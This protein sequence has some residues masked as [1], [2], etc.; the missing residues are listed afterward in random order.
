M[1]LFFEL[2]KIIVGAQQQ[3]SR[4]PSQKEWEQ[5]FV[6]LQQQSLLGVG[7]PV[8]KTLPKEQCPAGDLPLV[9]YT[10]ADRLRLM[11]VALN[12]KSAEVSRWFEEQGF[13]TC[14]LKGQGNAAMYPDPTLR[15]SGDIDVWLW[16]NDCEFQFGELEKRR[17]KI[18]K[19]VKREVGKQPCFYHHVDFP[20]YENVEIEVHFTPS[21]MTDYFKNRLLQRFVVTE[22]KESFENSCAI[23]DGLNI[24]IPTWRL[25]VVFQLIHM[26]K[27]LFAEGIGLRQ[28]MDYYYLL[29]T[30]TDKDARDKVLPVIRALHLETFLASVMWVLHFV[31]GLK[32]EFWIGELDEH[33]GKLLL[34]EI[35]SG[36][37]FGK[38]GDHKDLG[39]SERLLKRM[40]LKLRR[41]WQ[42]RQLVRT[43]VLWSPIFKTWHYFWR[44]TL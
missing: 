20:K 38:F 28:V 6:L 18:L 37:N 2:L 5:L 3:F 21:W 14:I 43:E 35:L 34:N 32:R 8:L 30:H 16:P 27:H 39:T 41:V 4:V 10:L 31:F 19:F 25:N 40:T 11:N 36:G 13:R 17:S 1:L 26:Q 22:A 12:K 7:M 33:N 44:K 29:R 9:W 15:N 42:F 23:G 24:N